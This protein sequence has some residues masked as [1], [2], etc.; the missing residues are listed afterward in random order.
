A[1]RTTLE[2]A[3]V[4]IWQEVLGVQPIGVEDNFFEL[5]GDSILS[6]QM[7][8]RAH[9]QKIHFKAR[10]VFQYPTIRGLADVAAMDSFIECERVLDNQGDIPLLPIQSWFL[11]Q[12]LA[13]PNYFNQSQLMMLAP[14][15]DLI[16]LKQALTQV[17]G[18]HDAFRIRY[19]FKTKRQ[20]YATD[21]QP[22]VLE[23][24]H[25][26]GVRDFAGAVLDETATRQASLNIEQGVLYR[27]ALIHGAPDGR[28]RLFLVIH[29]W[30]VDGVSWRI[31]FEDLE[32]TYDALRQG[33]T[34][35]L[36]KE[37]MSYK[38]WAQ[39]LNQIVQQ[40]HPFIREAKAY[41]LDRTHPNPLF[42]EE[43]ALEDS[44]DE[45]IELTLNPQE[46][47]ILL[48]ELPQAYRTRIND[49]L[50]TALVVAYC[51]LS[52]EK[53]LT[54]HMEGH[55]REEELFGKGY[56]LSKTVG[57]FTSLYPVYFCLED[58]GDDLFK[59]LKQ[60][61]EQL[62]AVPGQGLGYGVLR[63]C[64]DRV[65]QDALR[66]Q[67]H[68]GMV[69][70]YLG[71][72]RDADGLFQHALESVGDH[73]SSKNPESSRL[74]FNSLVRNGCF[75]LGVRYNRRY[76]RKQVIL[77]L[78]ANYETILRRLINERN[79]AAAIQWLTPSDLPL[80]Q[81]SQEN[82]N[83]LMPVSVV[84]AYPLTPL[85][86]GLLYHSLRE[87]GHGEY[88]V[89][90]AFVLDFTVDEALFRQAWSYVVNQ[91][92]S[93][94]ASFVWQG[95]ERPFQRIERAVTLPWET[96]DW[97]EK[98]NWREDLAQLFQQ[99]GVRGFDLTKAPLM[100]FYWIT[101]SPK[102]R[103]FVFVN[104]HLLLDGWSSAILLKHV[105]AAYQ[106]LL[107]KGSVSSF[108]CPRYRDYVHW[109]TQQDRE[110]ARDYW[111]RWLSDVEAGTALPI[112]RKRADETLSATKTVKSALTAEETQQ[113]NNWVK[114][115]GLTMNTLIQG[116]WGLMLNRYTGQDKV[117][118]G[119]VVSG[120]AVNLHQ[121][122]EQV[123][124]L[125][126][127]IAL[128]ID[129]H[130]NTKG[131]DYLQSLQNRLAE[132]QQYAYV[133][134]SEIQRWAGLDG[135]TPL[136]EH[137]VVFENYPIDRAGSGSSALAIQETIVKEQTN[138][139]L[140]LIATPGD[141]LSLR[142][143]FDSR[144][145][146]EDDMRRLMEHVQNLL[147]AL[148]KYPDSMVR[149]YSMLSDRERQRL[150]V[151]FNTTERDYP[152][153]KTV[154]QLFEEQV[155]RT[156]NHV[157]VVYEEQSLTY[158][159]LN[160]KAN[161]LAHYL[162]EQ[163]VG[164]EVLVA[165]CCERSLEMVVGILAIL[166]AGGA[167]V[168]LDPSYPKERLQFMLKDTKAPLLLSQK[169][170][171]KSLPKTK[172]KRVFLDELATLVG[173]YPTTNPA[174]AALANNLAYV[175]YTSG[176]TGQPKGV[177]IEHRGIS[178]HLLW[179]QEYI[180]LTSQD[181]FLQ[182][183]AFGFDGA[184]QS[185]F[186]PLLHGAVVLFSKDDSLPDVQ[187]L[188]ALVEKNKASTL[189]ATPSILS[190]MLDEATRSATSSVKR[191]IFGGEALHG[192]L[193]DK[194]LSRGIETIYNF[195]GPTECSVL[196]TAID[197]TDYRFYDTPPIGRP[198]SNTS[199]YILDEHFQPAPIGVTGELYIGGE[200]LARGYLNRPELTAERF[201]VNP[202]A[203]EEDKA[204]GRN[205]RLYR[206]GDLCRY[207]EDGNIEYIGRIDHQVKIRGFRIELGE[208]E[209]ALLSH[210]AV[211]EAVVVA[212]DV[213]EGGKRLV[214]YYVL[215]PKESPVVD[216]SDLR[217]YLKSRLPDYMV[218]SFLVALEAMPLTPNGKLDRK[219]LPSPEGSAIQRTYVAPRT[220]LEE[221]LVLIWQE[222]L[223][224]QPIGVEDNFFE[225]GGHSL[226]A[227]QLIHLVEWRLKTKV[228]LSSFLQNASISELSHLLTRKKAKSLT[229]LVTLNGK[230]TKTPLFLI[231]PVGG[232]VFCY[233]ELAQLLKADRP[234]YGVQQLWHV[235]SKEQS[236]SIEEMAAAYISNIKKIQHEGPYCLMGWSMGGLI[237]HEMAY[238]LE[239]EKDSLLFLGMIDSYVVSS[240]AS[241]EVFHKKQ[242]LLN[243]F[244]GLAVGQ[245]RQLKYTREEWKDMDDDSL[246]LD[247]MAKAVDA[248]LIAPIGNSRDQF[249][250]LFEQEQYN[251]ALARSFSPKM[252]KS[253][254]DLIFASQNRVNGKELSLEEYKKHWSSFSH[255]RIRIYELPATHYSLLQ[256]PIVRLLSD[257]LSDILLK[258]K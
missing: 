231:H 186:W 250:E 226:L 149:S 197:V 203:S 140:N 11:E 235:D 213:E 77:A 90:L 28:I 65:T 64:A 138:Y 52:H 121:I 244:M 30:V 43:E 89:R 230:G 120:R 73:T 161:Q 148:V 53:T 37:K 74:A 187:S 12:N 180:H 248:K 198:I 209:T 241:N 141:R 126:N 33:K 55:G 70:N 2:E 220:T 40:D 71:Q 98:A 23:D 159:E 13:E 24:I 183:F 62:R 255:G 111:T 4:L 175:I 103:L 137:L 227:V 76:F 38:E 193:I 239:S 115:H 124:L 232:Q 119:Q 247:M 202:F 72:F 68:P 20:W 214:G 128:K 107:E 251:L 157:A 85:Q 243:F 104:H 51:R 210:A 31:L 224:V 185:L 211:K 172:A 181:V 9:R 170:L 97:Q 80:L 92:D 212:Q 152:K 35:R 19:D 218:P 166:K 258:M 162:R 136:V 106:H 191:M 113:L 118:F 205:L 63:Y 182:Q 156:P 237:A 254:L 7:L 256:K 189:Y 131:L 125:I 101:L 123:G 147:W 95:V 66:T 245:S 173:D 129:I 154:H 145:Y 190:A 194:A 222:V 208:I 50:L 116:A 139:R 112:Q 42:S 83:R 82:I 122:E 114:A 246:L 134:L 143:D 58:A 87:E 133:P 155:E 238:Q 84:D 150:L 8:A 207:L 32:R 176:S 132:S 117:V 171:Q 22:L 228:S 26:E 34:P 219:A 135:R 57:W 240:F 130:S 88:I 184:V 60:V 21:F 174:P 177:M 236:S 15:T 59:A 48:K 249:M 167:Y 151:D 102:Q 201:V 229:P 44:G 49:I 221:A 45:C 153:D 127:T 146:Q 196:S 93:L 144:C 14:E 100:R 67:K 223:G 206:T 78:L 16:L 233:R 188:L 96:L 105:M 94:R 234:I 41:W 81:L 192:T 252:I 6:I 56:D 99:E 69:F 165:I 25:L 17:F 168:P 75:S 216:A 108:S 215:A 199:C 142:I 163:G 109:M 217:T 79:Q 253:D 39:L 179:S 3:L 5:G 86:E 61:K 47:E 204:Q 225:L 36:D 257:V 178:D 10:D 169:A 200:G 158:K 242:A 160:E 46:T 110:A 29:H 27:A 164:P 1:P 91:Y 54:V 195:Y 18:H